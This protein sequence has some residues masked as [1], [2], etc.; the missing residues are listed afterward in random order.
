MPLFP[1]CVC[2]HRFETR[3]DNLPLRINLLWEHTSIARALNGSSARSVRIDV[4]RDR[5]FAAANTLV[6]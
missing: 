4:I 6:L 2:V 3:Y 1:F 5:V